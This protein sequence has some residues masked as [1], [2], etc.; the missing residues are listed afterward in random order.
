MPPE[1]KHRQLPQLVL[2]TAAESIKMP[3]ASN[4]VQTTGKVQEWASVKASA[5]QQPGPLDDQNFA[6]LRMLYSLTTAQ[7]S[8]D[9]FL[10]SFTLKGHFCGLYELYSRA[11]DKKIHDRVSV[12]GI[13]SEE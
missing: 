9:C 3:C 5:D 10:V 2:K 12:C 4:G 1:L 13:T 7:T 8:L 11:T 6:G